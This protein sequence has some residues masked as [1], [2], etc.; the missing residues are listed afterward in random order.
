MTNLTVEQLQKWYRKQLKKKSGDFLKQAEKSYKVV[1]RALQDVEEMTKEFEDEDMD[2]V[3]GIASRFA[4][5][6]KEI[7]EQDAKNGIKE[8][9]LWVGKLNRSIVKRNVMT[10][11]YGATHDGFKKQLM[12]EL[13]KLDAKSET[14]SYLKVKANWEVCN[15][16][17]TKNREA[18]ESE[19]EKLKKERGT[20]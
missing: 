20:H 6:V 1:E 11:A 19:S 7:V 14:G 17:A 9:K 15:Y 12:K 18:I 5:K 16:L 8:A 10:L 13:R 2:E 3:D 4:M